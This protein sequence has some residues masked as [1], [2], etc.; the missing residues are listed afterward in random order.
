MEAKRLGRTLAV[1]EVKE[2]LAKMTTRRQMLS[3]LKM[4]G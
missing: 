4:K 2:L 3:Y 1:Q